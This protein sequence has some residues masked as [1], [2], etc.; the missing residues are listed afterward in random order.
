[1]NKKVLRN[2]NSI[3]RVIGYLIGMSIYI[4]GMLFIVLGLINLIK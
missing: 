1:M 4:V 2:L 3:G